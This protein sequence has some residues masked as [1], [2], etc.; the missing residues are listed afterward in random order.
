ML[1]TQSL[2]LV[3]LYHIAHSK[4]QFIRYIHIFVVH[5]IISSQCRP[6]HKKT[7]I[8]LNIY[9]II[10]S[11]LAQLGHNDCKYRFLIENHLFGEAVRH[12]GKGIVNPIETKITWRQQMKILIKPNVFHFISVLLSNTGNK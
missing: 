6:C 4:Y 3:F 8:S 9:F 10:Y 12:G 1:S 5:H 7:W 11:I 2:P